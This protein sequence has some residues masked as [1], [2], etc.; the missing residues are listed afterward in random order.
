MSYIT[1]A[2][3]ASQLGRPRD[4]D[5]PRMQ[6]CCDAATK[7]IDDRCGRTVS[8]ADGSVPAMVAEV[9]LSLAV[10]I[11]KQPDATFGIMGLSETGPVRTPRDL[12]VRYDDQLIPYYEPEAAWGIA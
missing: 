2:E 6:R 1:P 3:L 7:A 12:V 4:V 8:Y 5:N 11:W 10:D 9:A